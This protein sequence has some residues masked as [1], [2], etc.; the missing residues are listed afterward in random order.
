M[1]LC[2]GEAV[3][4]LL[5]KA[6]GTTRAVS[7]GAAVNTAIA[8]S[9]LGQSAALFAGLS[10]DT[11]GRHI[12]NTLETEGVD[13][14]RSPVMDAPC[15]Q[16]IVDLVDGSPQFTF[17]DQDSAGRALS[18]LHM[19]EIEAAQALVFGGLSLIHRPAAGVFEALM[20]MAGD[21]RLILLDVNIRPALIEDQ[22]EDYR[23]RLDR[24]MLMAD[25]LKFSDEDLAWLRPDP[26]EQLLQGRAS[27]VI[28]THGAKGVTLYSRH[29]AQHFPAAPVPVKDTVG[30]GDIF[31]AGF[32]ASLN[33]QGCMTPALMAKSEAAALN[34]AVAYGIRSA[35]FSV[36]RHGSDGPTKEEL[37]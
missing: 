16:A 25:L 27:V 30:A 35:T 13:F 12:Q 7:G 33:T 28:H 3:I 31:N 24:M 14:N 10:N 23:K 15:P 11:H 29:G 26:P 17:R 32:L 8:L 19:P 9:R 34:R 21:S 6:D 1:I 36:T 20:Q 22:E 37:L 2:C 5:P 18:F 4:D